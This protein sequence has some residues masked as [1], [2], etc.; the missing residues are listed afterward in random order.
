M[1]GEDVRGECLGANVW[2][3]MSVE[4]MFEGRCLGADVRGDECPGGEC[5]GRMFEGRCPGAD[6]REANVR[7]ANVRGVCSCPDTQQHIPQ[8]APEITSLHHVQ[9]AKEQ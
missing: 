8:S 9:A 5:P 2:G 3:R 6:V 7:G 1:T 4:R